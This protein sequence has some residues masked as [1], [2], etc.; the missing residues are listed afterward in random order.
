MNRLNLFHTSSR[1]DLPQSISNPDLPETQSHK[2]LFA[3]LTRF[4]LAIAGFMG[5]GA[6]IIVTVSMIA[7]QIH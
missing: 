4:Y 1:V 7:L 3:P 2:R 5:C 6:A